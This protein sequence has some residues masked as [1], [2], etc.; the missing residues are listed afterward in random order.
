MNIM[1]NGYEYSKIDIYTLKHILFELIDIKFSPLEALKA[2][3]IVLFDLV[4]AF[5]KEERKRAK[6]AK[7][8]KLTREMNI[9]DEQKKYWNKIQSRKIFVKKYY[10]FILSSEKLDRL[11]G[12]GVS[13]TFGDKMKGNPEIQRLSFKHD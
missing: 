4:K 2:N 12:F 7:K 8:A 10:D 3:M 5:C 11:R 6:G 1:I 13:N 9:T